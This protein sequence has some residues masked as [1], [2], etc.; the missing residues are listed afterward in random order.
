MNQEEQAVPQTTVALFGDCATHITAG[1]YRHT[2]AMGLMNWVSIQSPKSSC[3][4][5]LQREKLD[6]VQMP[7]YD[8]R[9]CLLDAHKTAIEFLLGEKADYLVLD[10][11]D[12]RKDIIVEQGTQACEPCI[13]DD[14]N[15]ESF[16]QVLDI[17]FQG[18]PI[19]KI[20]WTEIPREKYAEAARAI[21]K[22]IGTVYQADEI[23]LLKHYN[24]TAYFDEQ[25]RYGYSQDKISES[26]RT[27]EIIKY[28]E[29]I[30]EA[31]FPNLHVIDFPEHVL[32]DLHHVFG[33]CSLHYHPLYYEY[34]RKALDIVFGHHDEEKLLLQQL[35]DLYSLRFQLEDVKLST[36]IREN[37]L[38]EK[39]EQS[40][41]MNTSDHTLAQMKSFLTRCHYIESYLDALQMLRQDVMILLAVRDTPGFYE[42]GVLLEKLKRLGFQRYPNQLWWTYVGAVYKGGTFVDFVST[43]AEKPVQAS[44]E[45][46]GRRIFLASK[47][48]RNGDISVIRLDQEDYSCNGRGMNLVVCDTEGNVIDSV[49]FDTHIM[50]QF[51][52][53][54][55]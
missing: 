48:Y 37:I 35:R 1:I 16:K 14:S 12:C 22:A 6:S 31:E 41:F 13:T 9:I 17:I 11:N 10:C 21:C 44:W 20:P 33:L 43:E 8:K 53:K 39:V 52:R 23:V 49:T 30:I 55:L 26:N 19:R 32:G 40:F 2:R 34:A 18:R 50:R 29:D 54:D 36:E 25:G 15:Q 47:S 24:A 3:F 38:E 28:V 46:N 4:E 45:M 7:N 27:T 51:R 42:G 5:N